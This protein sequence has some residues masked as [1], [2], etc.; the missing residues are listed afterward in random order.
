M[1][2]TTAEAEY[3][4][5]FPKPKYRVLTCPFCGRA[6]KLETRECQWQNS[7]CD[8]W[9]YLRCDCRPNPMASGSHSNGYAENGRTFV[10]TYTNER[11]LELAIEQAIRDWNTRAMQCVLV[12]IEVSY[13]Q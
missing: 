7:E 10:R 1:K 8:A 4:S 12:D 5:W 13:A 11:A 3:Q 2:T 6:P 9:A